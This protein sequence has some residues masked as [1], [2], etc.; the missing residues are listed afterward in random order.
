MGTRAD[1]YLGKGKDAEWL[2]SIAWDGYREGI[3]HEILSC[4]D[5]QEYRTLVTEFIAGREDGTKPEHG[6][7][8]PWNNSSTTDCSYWFWGGKVWDAR[9]EYQSEVYAPC[10]EPEP[11]WGNVDDE[12]AATKRWLDGNDE[13]YFPD[14]TQ[15]KNTTLGKRSGLIV[16]AG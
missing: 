15:K 5:E 16:I 12:E 9:G 6:W 7:P 11:D 3:P 8:W 14:M 13:V 1:F 4:H 10:D 2:G